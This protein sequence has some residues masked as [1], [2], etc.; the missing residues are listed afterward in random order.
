MGFKSARCKIKK[1]LLSFLFIFISCAQVP[2]IVPAVADLESAKDDLNPISEDK[3]HPY[4]IE[5]N[6]NVEFSAKACEANLVKLYTAE[7]VILSQKP[8]PDYMSFVKLSQALKLCWNV[9]S[10]AAFIR[11]YCEK[12]PIDLCVSTTNIR[13]LQHKDID[14]FYLKYS[15]DE[16]QV[17]ERLYLGKTYASYKTYPACLN[18]LEFMLQRKVYNLTMLYANEMLKLARKKS[19]SRKQYYIAMLA[20]ESNSLSDIDYEDFKFCAEKMEVDY[21]SHRPCDEF[22]HKF[23]CDYFINNTVDRDAL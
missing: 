11:A 1:I 5:K 19:V 15:P 3:P 17:F 6:D 23:I 10:Y 16:Y 12:D 9:P 7:R 4:Q 13:K 8:Y 14:L 18:H 2:T 21:D 22:K 20:A